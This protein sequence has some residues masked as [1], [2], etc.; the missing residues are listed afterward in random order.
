MSL[1]IQSNGIRKDSQHLC[2]PSWFLCSYIKYL[3][4][5]PRRMNSLQTAMS[6][7]DLE[8]DKQISLKDRRRMRQSE[9]YNFSST[10]IGDVGWVVGK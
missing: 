10:K 6:E 7:C 9:V 2:P 5:L 1:S 8:K 4:T 3:R